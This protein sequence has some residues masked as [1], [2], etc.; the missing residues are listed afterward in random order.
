MYPIY[1][2]TIGKLQ[3][4]ADG[5]GVG[6]ELLARCITEAFPKQRFVFA[7]NVKVNTLQTGRVPQEVADLIDNIDGVSIQN[8]MKLFSVRVQ[9]MQ[10]AINDVS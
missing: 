6:L 10:D 3:P 1:V 4:H 8:L 2:D 5:G 9:L 7:R